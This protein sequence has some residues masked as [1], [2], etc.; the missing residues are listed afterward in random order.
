VQ[1]HANAHRLPVEDCS[2]M[3][4]TTRARQAAARASTLGER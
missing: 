4:F 2:R 1:R 3:A